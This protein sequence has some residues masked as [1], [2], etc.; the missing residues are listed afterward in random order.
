MDKNLWDLPTYKHTDGRVGIDGLNGVEM[1]QAIA[2]TLM[3]KFEE[4]LEEAKLRCADDEDDTSLGEYIALKSVVEQLEKYFKRLPQ[5]TLYR[6]EIDNMRRQNSG[7]H[8]YQQIA[9]K[10]ADGG[11]F[12]VF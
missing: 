9:T 2:S 5:E 1:L 11:T 6:E 7:Y 4:Q 3:P 10:Y 12:G 8:R